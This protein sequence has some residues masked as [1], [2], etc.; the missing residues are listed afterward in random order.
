MKKA[1]LLAVLLV[2][3]PV[4]ACINAP[5]TTDHAGRH[6]ETFEYSGDDLVGMMTRPDVQQYWR[7]RKKEIVRQAL[8]KPDFDSLTNLGVLLIYQENYAAATRLFV[9]IEALYPGR[10][11]TAANLGTALEL[12]GRDA[13]ALRWIRLGIRRDRREHEGTEWLHA[14]ILMAKLALKDDP[15]FLEGRSVAGIAFDTAVV[16]SLPA[17]Y[18]RGNDGQPV[19]PYELERAFAYQLQERLPFVKPKDPVVA[20]LLADWATL[21]LAGGP[22]E[23]AD[24]LYRL[25]QR[26]GEPR[27]PL[28]AARLQH[29]RRTLAVADRVPATDLGHC[30][31]CPPLSSPSPPDASHPRAP[32]DPP[33]PPPPPA[34]Y[35]Q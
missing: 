22:I 32:G 19:K 16:P 6:F 13:L 33:P 30:P 18:P 10:H 31:I 5:P 17:T 29:I 25:A 2:S 26:Y 28:M 4:L 7:G 24:A 21:N 12:M 23:N 20:N 1:W 15:R 9:Q 14:R 35:V 11:R 27:T 34:P 8:A 3:Q